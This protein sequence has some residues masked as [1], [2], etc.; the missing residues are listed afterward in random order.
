MKLEV[1]RQISRPHHLGGAGVESEVCVLDT[2]QRT[3]GVPITIVDAA[4]RVLF[5]VGCVTEL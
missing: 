5:G 4:Q 3:L 2:D 1:P